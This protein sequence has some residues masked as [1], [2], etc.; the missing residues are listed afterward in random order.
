MSWTK[1]VKIS[2]G[3]LAGKVFDTNVGSMS[4]MTFTNAPQP[5]V[6]TLVVTNG[7]RVLFADIEI[8]TSGIWGDLPLATTV[9]FWS[10]EINQSAIYKVELRC[11]IRKTAAYN[12]ELKV[13][14]RKYTDANTYTDDYNINQNG[15]A[16]YYVQLHYSN[17]SYP[18][19]A[20]AFFSFSEYS[21][22]SYIFFGVSEDAFY[23]LPQTHTYYAGGASVNYFDFV[24]LL[25]GDL[26][27]EEKSDEFGDAST[28]EGG[29]NEGGGHGT[30]DFSS[31]E[32][33]I[34]NKPTLGVTSAGFINV[35]KIGINELQ[36]LGEKLFPHFLPAELL[37]DPSQMTTPEMLATFLKTLYGFLISPAGTTIA[38]TDNLGIIDILMN[39]KLIDYIL[40]CHIIPTS[41]SGAV[42]SPLK[43]G[44]RTFNDFQL[45][46]ATDD[47]VDVDC[48]SLN[49]KEAFGNFLDYTCKTEIYLPF[50]G[51]VPL[52]N[53]YWNNATIQVHYRFNIV[54]GSF[55]VRLVTSRDDDGKP[56]VL[57]NSVIA[58]YGGV[59]CVHF[60]ITGLQYSNVVAGLV[61]G[62]A[63]AM[64]N[65][66]SGN[67]AGVATSLMN[68]AMLRPEAPSS[69][70]YNASSSFL[71]QKTPYLVIKR[72]APQCSKTYPHEV[73]LPLNVEC[74]LSSLSGMTVIDNPVLNIHCTDNEYKEI[75]ELMKQGIIL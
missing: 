51:F 14:L 72:P 17:Y 71:G 65:G 26:P 73:G 44:Y 10:I 11:D 70:G 31:D 23:T 28:P 12:A 62:T 8:F 19:N 66:A 69:N 58:Q 2:G 74:K 36:D 22:E 53:E 27:V 60:P 16:P 55:Q 15:V 25:T 18:V 4:D 64:A 48:G 20:Y 38:L 42:V 1:S 33:P 21:G 24:T 13:Y 45:A 7:E 37:G 32:I 29:Y 49:I 50:V 43:I 46:K 30:F 34:D 35:Y 39:G 6:D 59:C 5:Q 3:V 68:T 9:L 56:C 47:Y 41:I 52:S 61:N 40:D 63:G 54:D 57:H 75:V 67:I